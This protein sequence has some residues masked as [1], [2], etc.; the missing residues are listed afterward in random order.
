[1]TCFVQY[2]WNKAH[3]PSRKTL[4][5]LSRSTTGTCLHEYLSEAHSY[6]RHGSHVSAKTPHALQKVASQNAD[7]FNSAQGRIRCRVNCRCH[8]PL[9]KMEC[10]RETA[11]PSFLTRY[12]KLSDRSNTKKGFSQANSESLIQQTLIGFE[13]LSRWLTFATISCLLHAVSS[14]EV[15]SNG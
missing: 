6:H 5:P 15:P 14:Q 2:S 7:F 10:L 4:S 3:C 11:R 1:M 12:R 8:V 9:S 13:A